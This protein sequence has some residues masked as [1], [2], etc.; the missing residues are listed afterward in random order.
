MQGAEMTSRAPEHILGSMVQAVLTVRMVTE[1]RRL[2]WAW[3]KKSDDGI[4]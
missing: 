2:G 3:Q 4:C 1:P